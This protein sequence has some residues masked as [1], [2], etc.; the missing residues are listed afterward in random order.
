M[1]FDDKK[2]TSGALKKAKLASEECP[3]KLFLGGVSLGLEGVGS[4]L[5][6]KSEQK[7]IL[8]PLSRFFVLGLKLAS[9]RF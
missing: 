4:G 3:F 8:L 9:S 5:E 1:S 2:K 6:R 7:N